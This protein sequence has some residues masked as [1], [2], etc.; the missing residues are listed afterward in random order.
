MVQPRSDVIKR[1]SSI[2]ARNR[3]SAALRHRFKLQ[4][5]DLRGIIQDALSAPAHIQFT[6]MSDTP[7]DDD[8]SLLD[9]KLNADK[10]RMQFVPDAPSEEAMLR[11][12]LAL[13]E[14]KMA[15]EKVQADFSERID[16]DHHSWRKQKTDLRYLKDVNGV[17]LVIA[18]LSVL[19]LMAVVAYMY[20]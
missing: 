3:A 11:L 10:P 6:I 1:Y 20:L 7:I 17:L 14:A 2:F 4:S 12:R 8:Y 13:L 16:V 18:A 5:D 19:L 9:Q 15:R